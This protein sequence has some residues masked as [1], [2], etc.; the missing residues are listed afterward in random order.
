M[1][2]T[3]HG[4]GHWPTAQ[5]SKSLIRVPAL[6][7]LPTTVWNWSQLSLASWVSANFVLS[8]NTP[9]TLLERGPRV[10]LQQEM[11]YCQSPFRLTTCYSENSVRCMCAP[12]TSRGKVWW[13]PEVYQTH[14]GLFKAIINNTGLF[15]DEKSITKGK[16]LRTRAEQ[17]YPGTDPGKLP[18][19][20]YQGGTLSWL[21]PSE[22]PINA[23][24]TQSGTNK[25]YV[26]TEWGNSTYE[27]L[28]LKVKN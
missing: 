12:Q 23:R 24:N 10:R 21:S 28:L 25:H 3:G 13:K 16:L 4:T 17:S 5:S 6:T 8:T 26:P 22:P 27:I 9:P 19:S 1:P 20:A 15:R 11:S 14:L 2:L 7:K 18:A